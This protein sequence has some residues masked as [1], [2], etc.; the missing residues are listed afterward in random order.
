MNTLGPYAIEQDYSHYVSKSSGVIFGLVGT[1]KKGPVNE[2]TLCTSS[3]DF[4]RKFGEASPDHLGLYAAMYY[5]SQGNRCYFVRAEGDTPAQKGVTTI[6]GLVENPT[7]NTESDESSEETEPEVVDPVNAITLTAKTPGTYF[8]NLKIIV[9]G[10][11]VGYKITVN[12]GIRTLETIMYQIGDNFNSAYF[13]AS[14]VT[15][16]ITSLV[17]GTYVVEGGTD[18]ATDLNSA[19]WIKALEKL[20]SS[21]Y[22]INLFAVPGISDQAVIVKALQIAENRGDALFLVDPPNNLDPADVADWH[23]GAGEYSASSTLYNSSY[24]ALYYSWQKIYDNNYAQYV[25]VPPSVIVASVMAKSARETA[26]WMPPAGMIRGKV[27][28]VIKPVYTP[29][30]GERDALYADTNA[31]NC[32]IDD[33]TEGLV[34]FGQK[35]LLRSQTALNRVNVR[36]LLNYLKRVIVAAAKYLTFEPNDS[37]TWNSFEDLVEPTLRS[38][39]QRRGL[40]AYKIVKGE[41]IVTND[42]ID[43]YR[44][45][46]KILIQPTKAAEEI[47]IYFTI[48]RTGV[49]FNDVL[50]N[51]YIPSI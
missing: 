23:N 44:M 47:P 50:D 39:G 49:D 13:D 26:I 3:T 42:D 48:T 16:G 7:P 51:D 10:S 12:D 18:S 35:T 31:V 28:G 46:C 40:Y 36:M 1:A 33:P 11:V 24:G 32:I 38:I 20:K 19:N 8:N 27:D 34:V 9:A 22:D 43:N 30:D 15:E 21:T 5:L 45:P 6:K 29:D 14:A 4:I 37:Y 2:P 17:P 25:D 41:E